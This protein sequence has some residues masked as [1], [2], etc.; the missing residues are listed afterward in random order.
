M[1]TLGGYRIIRKI[2]ESLDILY[3]AQDSTLGRRQAA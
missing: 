1:R 3:E 2:A